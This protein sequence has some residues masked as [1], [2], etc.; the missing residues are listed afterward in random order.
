MFPAAAAAA[1]A[2]EAAA[3]RAGFRELCGTAGTCSMMRDR[4]GNCL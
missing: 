4:R 3:T 1:A 2:S